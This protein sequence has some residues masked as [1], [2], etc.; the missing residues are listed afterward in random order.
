MRKYRAN[1][2]HLFSGCLCHSGSLKLQIGSIKIT[3]CCRV[4]GFAT[5]HLALLTPMR[6]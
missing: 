3:I 5:H 2:R 6:H 4:C 1:N